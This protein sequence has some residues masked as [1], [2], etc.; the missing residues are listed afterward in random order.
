VWQRFNNFV[1][2][3]ATFFL[4]HG[5]QPLAFIIATHGLLIIQWL[6]LSCVKEITTKTSTDSCKLIILIFNIFNSFV[7]VV[8]LLGL[9]FVLFFNTIM[10]FII[11][12]TTIVTII[13]NDL[14]Y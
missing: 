14:L 2:V 12:T 9:L 4:I 1:L 6:K 13:M 5:L 8:V 3:K 11:I 10:K 7:R